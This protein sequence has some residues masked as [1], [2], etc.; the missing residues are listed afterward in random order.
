MQP[1]RTITE[2]APDDPEEQE[3]KVEILTI[4]NAVH[5]VVEG[6]NLAMILCAFGM[7]AGRLI[8]QAPT[9]DLPA[10]LRL[11]KRFARGEYTIESARQRAAAPKH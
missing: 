5:T 4:A 6:H 1:N 10:G 9:P 7:V 2:I 11:M 8:A 3:R